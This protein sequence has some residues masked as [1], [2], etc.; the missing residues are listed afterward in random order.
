MNR[1]IRFPLRQPIMLGSTRWSE[2][3]LWA[4]K[5]ILNL[6]IVKRQFSLKIKM[7]TI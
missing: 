7:S 4:E 1:M 3:L 5:T 2:I 6:D